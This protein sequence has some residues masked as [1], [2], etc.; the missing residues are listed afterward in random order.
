[1][2]TEPAT[3]ADLR[4]GADLVEIS[5]VTEAISRFGPRYLRRVFTDR[6]V[7]SCQGDPSVVAAGLAARF[8]AKEATVKVLRPSGAGPD[9]RSIEVVRHRAGWCDL[10]LTGQARRL[11]DEAGI[12][13]LALSMSHEA[14]MAGAVVV[15]MC[16]AG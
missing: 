8:A 16:S 14:G 2:P 7:D 15:A 10:H 5:Q 9:W 1:M 4:V 13:K 6:E 11:A 3:A 12:S